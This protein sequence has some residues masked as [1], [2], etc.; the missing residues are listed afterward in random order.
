MSDLSVYSFDIFDTC[1]SRTYE[2][3][4]DL[5]YHLGL[6]IAPKNT[7]PENTHTF[8]NSFLIARIDAEIKAN[9]MHGKK[10][11]CHIHEIYSLLTPLPQCTY[12]K[13]DIMRIELQLEE[14]CI[15][16]IQSTKEIIDKLR[17]DNTRIIFISDMYLD[18]TFIK[19]LLI[20]HG[21]F[22]E[23][24]GLYVSSENTL[25]KRSGALFQH[26]L[27]VEKIQP[28]EILHH[29]DDFIADVRRPTRMGIKAQYISESHYLPFES[30]TPR[31]VNRLSASRINATLKH[32]RLTNFHNFQKD[33]LSI[34]NTITLLLT[35]FVLW[36]FI[37]A[38]KKGI[39]TLYF[40]AKDS[41]ITYKIA[42][43]LSIYFPLIA[44]KYLYGSRRA[45]LTP[46]IDLNNQAWKRLAIP[47]GKQSSVNDA[48]ERINFPQ[49]TIKKISQFSGISEN[50]LTCAR[51]KFEASELLDKIFS[52][53]HCKDLLN[54]HISREREICL[55]YFKQEGLLDNE[56][57]AIVDTGWELNCQAALKRIISGR[58]TEEHTVGFYFGL[59]NDHLP[60][61]LAGEAYGFTETG[62]IFSKRRVA[63]EHCF[64][65]STHT[66]TTGYIETL[67]GIAPVFA[68]DYR[69]EHEVNYSKIL[70]SFALAFAD[71]LCD[72]NIPIEH[73]ISLRN[74]FTQNASSLLESPKI[75]DLTLLKGIKVSG[76]S[77]HT[78]ETLV[79]IFTPL[80]LS[81][82][83]KILFLY[84]KK[85]QHEINFVWLEASVADSNTIIRLLFKI[86]FLGKKKYAVS[87][88]VDYANKAK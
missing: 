28:E 82:L 67:N 76:D 26:V 7:S 11:S 23:G 63:V 22:K 38:Q 58:K 16:A 59:A 20:E 85:R 2:K 15:Y 56:N 12:S 77:R 64:F 46:S 6:M 41:D 68:K 69:S 52:N 74:I 19:A 14:Q 3:P 80:H 62:S 78:K 72:L 86:L 34:L 60:Q 40:L 39:H 1:I 45:W 31:E 54:E 55:K 84:T 13:F 50:E 49:E 48:L 71:Q 61:E 75:N 81:D 83:L 42:K 30:P 79:S 4:S 17:V 51:T 44:V 9:R 5:F 47:N 73:L 25:T 37:Q 66:S 36:T 87:S 32:L 24:D 53:N 88:A 18:K 8:A 35:E 10:R 43:K 27:S 57:W 29:G 33:S 65:A 21:F 70:H